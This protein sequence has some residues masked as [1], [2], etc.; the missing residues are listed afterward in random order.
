MSTENKLEQFFGGWQNGKISNPKLEKMPFS[1]QK[2]VG[3]DLILIKRL[4]F[5]FLRGVVTLKG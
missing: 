1:P 3:K 2:W 4:E 5:F